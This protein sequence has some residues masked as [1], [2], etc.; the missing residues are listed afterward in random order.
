MTSRINWRL[1]PVQVGVLATF[2]LTSFW[3]RL[4]ETPIFFARIYFSK[5]AI[6]LP[7]MLTIVAWFLTGM[8]GFNVFRQGGIRAGWAVALLALVIWMYASSAWAFMRGSEAQMVID[9][10]GTAVQFGVVALFVLVA[11]CAGPPPSV[12]IPVLIL[13]LIGNAYIGGGQVAAQSSIGLDFL[14]E[15]KLNANQSGVSV[16]QAE[17]VRWLRPY[18]LLPHPNIFAGVMLVGLLALVYWLLAEREL[19][20]TLALIILP[21][22]LWVFLLTFSRG[23]YLAFAAGAFVLLPLLW[24][25]KRHENG[26]GLAFIVLLMVGAAFFIIYRP[27]LLART[28]AG[29]ESTEVYSIGERNALM[30]T[31]ARAIS[32]NPL[33]GVGAGNF[34][35]RASYYLHYANSPVRGNN[36]HQV[37]MSVWAELGLIGLSIFVLTMLLGLEAVYQRIRAGDGDVIGRSVLLAGFIALAIAGLFEHY[38]YTLIQMQT[39]W[40]G[41]L[42]IAMQPGDEKSESAHPVIA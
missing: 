31:A 7:M 10:T 2:L 35:W 41:L 6:L 24:R 23:G 22:T 38:P 3:L 14:G 1:L 39:L 21:A 11:A 5:F 18:G 32:D 13:G 28:G 33:V 19:L 20:H 25:T 27:L 30:Q 17:G 34:P 12:V 40:W 29:L 15:F 42:A 9:A 36:V 26:L 4:D 37:V 16:I 8:P